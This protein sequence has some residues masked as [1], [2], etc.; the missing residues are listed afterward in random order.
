MSEPILTVYATTWCGDCHR[1]RTF[2][3]RHKV[4]YRWVDVDESPAAEQIIVR[5][6]NGSRSVPTLVFPDGSTLTEPNTRQLAEKLNI[7]ID[8]VRSLR[9]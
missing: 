1:A 2:L 4:A 5:I 3:D 6:N 7:D 9:R 8:P